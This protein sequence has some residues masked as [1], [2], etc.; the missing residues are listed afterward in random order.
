MVPL[1]LEILSLVL[2]NSVFNK[3]LDN[4]PNNAKYTSITT[5]NDLLYAASAVIVQQITE[6]IREARIYAII[7]D[8]I[9]QLSLCICY[10]SPVDNCIKE[11]FLG[12]TDCHEL[13]AASLSHLIIAQPHS[14]GLSLSNH[15]AQCYD[16]ALVMSGHQSEVQKP[17]QAEAGSGSV[18]IHCY[19][20]C[21][22]LIV[23]KIA[24][25]IDKVNDFLDY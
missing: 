4:R 5:Q 22:N 1:I 19:A 23:V 8:D 25:S 20:H 14:L 7:A 18:Y 2:E 17:I 24:Y 12:F 11:C 15:I 3:F 9:E 10:V 16:S 13:D 21:L 6:E